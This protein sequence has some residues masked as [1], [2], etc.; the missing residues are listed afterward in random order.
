[1]PVPRHSVFL[2]AGRPS[3]HPTNSIKALKAQV[4]RGKVKPYLYSALLR[5]AHL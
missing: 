4:K 2:Q 5:A 3:C 1:M